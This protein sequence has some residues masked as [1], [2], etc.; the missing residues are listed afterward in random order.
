MD[1]SEDE[2]LYHPMT[3]SPP[4]PQFYDSHGRCHLLGRL[5]SL[6]RHA[7]LGLFPFHSY[8]EIKLKVMTGINLSD[9][10]LRYIIN[11]NEGT[12]LTFIHSTN[13]PRE[14]RYT[15]LLLSA[16]ARAVNCD[17]DWKIPALVAFSSPRR[18]RQ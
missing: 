3:S 7:V 15:C 14:P 16:G 1:L 17:Q 8:R 13:T 9:N 4:A 12:P 2:N 5:Q 11:T 10:G 6:L 18:A